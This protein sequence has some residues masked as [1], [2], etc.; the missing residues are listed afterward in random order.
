MECPGV[1]VSFKSGAFFEL[2]MFPRLQ[3]KW[4]TCPRNRYDQTAQSLDL[5]ER[6]GQSY[7][8]AERSALTGVPRFPAVCLENHKKTNTWIH[9]KHGSSLGPCA[10]Y[11][12]ILHQ[13]KY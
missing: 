10:M 4:Q 5:S 11:S 9:S 7:I 6:S 13:P 3:L 1:L 8:L 12:E 2:H